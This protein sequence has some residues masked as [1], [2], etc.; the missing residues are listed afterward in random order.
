[1]DEPPKYANWKKPEANNYFYDFIYMKYSEKSNQWGH[2]T[3]QQL[4]GFQGK[5]EQ[6]KTTNQQEKGFVVMEG[7]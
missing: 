7:F 3:D 6:E 1:M 2:K 4:S 5:E